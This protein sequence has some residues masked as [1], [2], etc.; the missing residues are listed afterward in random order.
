[1]EG[2]EEKDQSTSLA[3][4]AA[5]ACL[6]ASVKEGRG[7]RTTILLTPMCLD[8]KAPRNKFMDIG[9]TR[10]VRIKL[11]SLCWSLHRTQVR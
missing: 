2:S 1:M 6:L 3:A 9:R 8:T 7:A 10:G 5:L 11:H 4:G